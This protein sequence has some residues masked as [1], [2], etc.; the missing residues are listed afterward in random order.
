MSTRRRRRRRSSPRRR[1]AF[2]VY[3]YS[4][5]HDLYVGQRFFICICCFPVPP[6]LVVSF[7]PFSQYI[8]V[9]ASE[10]EWVQVRARKVEIAKE[11]VPLFERAGCLATSK[12]LSSGTILS[13]IGAEPR[14]LLAGSP[15]CARVE[16]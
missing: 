7:I 10:R 6:S 15:C 5:H 3:I 12:A 13:P 14:L 16:M 4:P 8:T 2:H 1:R 11:L 9:S